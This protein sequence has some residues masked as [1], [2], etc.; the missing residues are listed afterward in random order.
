MAGYWMKNHNNREATEWISKDGRHIPIGEMADVHLYNAIRM[1]ERKA[2][3]LQ[4][5][6]LLA[7]PPPNVSDRSDAVQ[8]AVN[9]ECEQR[10]QAIEKKDLAEYLGILVPLREEATRRGID[11]KTP[12]FSGSNG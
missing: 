7:G 5:Q 10:A 12:V 2:K 3:L 4:V 1:L 11:W 6:E 9:L 8:D